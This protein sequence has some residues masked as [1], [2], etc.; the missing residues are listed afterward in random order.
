V[1][2]DVGQEPERGH[3]EGARAVARHGRPTTREVDGWPAGTLGAVVSEYPHSALV[4][5][6]TE[7]RLDDGL[8]AHE[9]LDDLVSVPYDALRLIQAAPVAAR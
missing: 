1:E 4:E 8:P 3:D 2:T 5:I 9:L 6:A 7:E